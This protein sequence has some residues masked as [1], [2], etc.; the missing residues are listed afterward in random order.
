MVRPVKGLVRSRLLAHLLA[1]TLLRPPKIPPNSFVKRTLPLTSTRSI[2]CA[3]VRLS[4]RK[5]MLC[6][7][8]GGGTPGPILG[9]VVPLE[10]DLLAVPAKVFLEQFAVGIHHLVQAAD[11]GVHV[12]AIA[13]D[14]AQVVLNV[15]VKSFPIFGAAAERWQ[16]VE[17]GMSLF[18]GQKLVAI[19]E[20]GF[21]A[22]AIQQ[23]ELAV[24]V[25]LRL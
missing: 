10:D 24:L 11:V 19:V 21:V 17:V 18:D 8:G 2:V 20:P 7:M 25:P 23:P 9:S 13:H 5:Q 14:L 3:H 16:I 22:R 12:M 6:D 15:S 1:C 4:I